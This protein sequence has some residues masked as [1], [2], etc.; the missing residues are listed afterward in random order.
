MRRRK[1]EKA[2]VP[3]S[4]AA[5]S[6]WG[7]GSRLGTL[8]GTG[9]MTLHEELARA[10]ARVR[11]ELLWFSRNASPRYGELQYAHAVRAQQAIVE[12]DRLLQMVRSRK[13]LEVSR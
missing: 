11:K 6:S 2:R 3:K 4:C 5:C 8:G 10:E 1:S 7:F 13:Q 12:R 9:G